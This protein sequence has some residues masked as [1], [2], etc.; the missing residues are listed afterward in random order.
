MVRPRICPSCKK[1][2]PP[3]AAVRYTTAGIY[4]E[5]CFNRGGGARR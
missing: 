3:Q 5:T 4:H 1:E 2:I